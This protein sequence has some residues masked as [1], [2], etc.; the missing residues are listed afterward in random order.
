MR[1]KHEVDGKYFSG[2]A[3]EVVQIKQM[4]NVSGGFQR[5]GEAAGLLGLLFYL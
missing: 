3:G 5:H 4:L 1:K 2:L